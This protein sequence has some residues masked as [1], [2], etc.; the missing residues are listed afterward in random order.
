[1]RELMTEN[2]DAAAV[3]VQ[4]DKLKNKYNTMILST[5]T[6][7]NQVESSYAP[8]LH[9]QECYYV[10]LSKIAT[11]YENVTDGHTFQ[12]MI[13]E[14]EQA[15]VNAFFRQRVI[16]NFK[17]EEKAEGKAV[18]EAFVATHGVI[19]EKLLTMNFDIFKLELLDGRVIL[20]PGKA[21]RFNKKEEITEQITA[22]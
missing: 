10:I 7:D 15:A 21:Y 20:G 18:I 13:L 19:V 17:C 5:K 3:K 22:K 1:M 6:S 4:L 2:F 14:D 9:H 8:Y 12:G 16:Y 11:H